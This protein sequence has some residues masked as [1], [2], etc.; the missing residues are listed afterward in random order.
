MPPPRNIL[1]QS[2][3]GI[4]QSNRIIIVG[5]VLV[6]IIAILYLTY[7][8]QGNRKEEVVEHKSQPTVDVSTK[9]NGPEWVQKYKDMKLAITQVVKPQTPQEIEKKVIND[10]QTAL[11]Q[12]VIEDQT[13][14]QLEIQKIED[15]NKIEEKKLEIEA[16]KSPLSVSVSAP[17]AT[18][19]QTTPSD[20]NGEMDKLKKA[21]E[22]V[23]EGKAPDPV[24][25]AS[26]P[27]NQDEK[28]NFLKSAPTDSEYLKNGLENPKSPYEVKAGSYI[29]AALISGINSDMPGSVKGQVRENVYDTVTGNYILIPQGTTI[30]GE[31]D[32]KVTFGQSRVLVVWERLIFPDGA[33]INLEKMQG[34]DIAGYA[35]FKEKLN[36]H[37]LKIYGNALL[38]SLVGAGYDILTNN[39]NSSANS[40]YNA[41]QAVAANVGQQLS[42]VAS[43]TLQRNMDVQPT[44]TIS[45]GFTF[46]IIVMK[47]MVLK[48][49]KDAEGTLAYSN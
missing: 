11:Q 31:Y 26:D 33:S 17:P 34:V 45:P 6:F 7:K 44:I 36:N 35:G 14:T 40:Q 29:P 43:K 22:A 49:I 8:A 18:A 38:L 16:M 4:Q 28:L 3:K 23:K 27:N 39:N 24:K 48:E 1:N 2:P 20:L 32:S 30:V 15:K 25:V 47:D 13:A 21:E 10:Q 9:D 19:S 12:S 41:Q 37:Y 46:N 42:D 5:L